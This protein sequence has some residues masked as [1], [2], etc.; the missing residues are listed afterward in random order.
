MDVLAP[1]VL[2]RFLEALT[3]HQK[4]WEHRKEK[5]EA[6]LRE[7]EPHLHHLWRKL[8][9]QFKGTPQQRVEQF[10][11][12]LEEHPGDEMGALQDDVDVMVERMVRKHEMEMSDVPFSG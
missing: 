4:G 3:P 5:E 6:V 11:E 8:Q 2:A 9:H 7:L 1:R 12:Y 10:R